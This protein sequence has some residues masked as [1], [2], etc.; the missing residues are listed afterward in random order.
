[1]R[2]IKFR[3][4]SKSFDMMFTNDMLEMATANM[5]DICKKKL[6]QVQPEATE[7]QMGIFLPTYDKD[8]ILMQYTGIKDKNGKEIYEGDI[9]KIQT[10]KVNE[11][12]YVIG[13]VVY[14]EFEG[15]YITN[16]G[17]ILGRVNHRTEVIGNIHQSRMHDFE[18]EE[19]N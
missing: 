12:D 11:D 9:V 14:S 8:L 15:M 5:V 19:E 1:M 6:K 13:T 10:V 18:I 3:G 7:I 2:D 16:K 17:Y 4:Y